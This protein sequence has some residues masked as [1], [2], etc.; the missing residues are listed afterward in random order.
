MRNKMM[1]YLPAFL[2]LANVLLFGELINMNPDPNGD[3]WIA[4][5]ISEPT[6]EQLARFNAMPVLK[7]PEFY[8]NR[9]D[10]LPSSIDNSLLPYFRPVFNQVNG[11]CG[12]ASGVGYN[13]TYEI[14]FERGTTADVPENQFPT[15][16]TYNFLNDG[17]DSGS[18]Y[19]DGWEI[20]KANGCPDVATYG[21]MS[22]EVNT[23][24]TWMSGYDKWQTGM[25]NRVKEQFNIPVSTPEGLQT[26]KHWFIDHADG[27][28]KGGVV[29]FAAGVSWSLG[30][31]PVGTPNAGQLV[32]KK[33]GTVMNHA[34]T[35]TGYNDSIRVDYNLDGRYTNDLDITGDGIIDMKDWEIGGL[36][37]VNSWGTGWGDSGKAWVMYRT[38][39]LD[40]S[41]GGIW[42]NVVSSLRAKSTVTPSLMMKAVI[43]HN[44]RTDL[45]I[46]AG[47]SSDT[48]ATVPEHTLS[49]P[50]F[51]YQGG[52][53][54]MEGDSNEVEFGLDITPLLS[55]V[56][57]DEP[58]KYFICVNEVDP[59]NY[60]EGEIIMFSVIDA[61]SNE[62][63]STQSN[64][65]IQDNSMT[66]MSLIKSSSF[67]PPQIITGS[68][69]AATQSEFYSHTLNSQSGS[70][71]YKWKIKYDYDQIENI[72]LF[73][74][75]ADS[76][77]ITS[78][79]DD[80]FGIIDLDFQFPF[81]GKLYDQVTVS[82][83]GS[84]LFGGAFEYISTEVN[85]IS[86]R[87]ISP[88]AADLSVNPDFEEGIIFYKNTEYL[89]VRWIASTYENPD[90][91]LDFAAK[92]YSNGNIEF[93]YG[94]AMSTDIIWAS[95][96]SDGSSDNCV[97]SSLS[98]INDPSG[99]K[100]KF[101]TADFP[102]GMQLSPEGTFSGTLACAPNS[103]DVTF[104]VIDYNNTS[105][106]KVLPFILAAPLVSPGN[107]TIDTSD[108]SA[109]LDWDPVSGATA[110]NIYRSN[111]PYGTYSKIGTSS[112]PNFEDTDLSGMNKYFYY[113]KADNS[114]K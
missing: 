91:D 114:K 90:A 80:G 68:L 69:P 33:W 109:F 20:I 87:N 43:S 103:W 25:N 74:E 24:T 35:F 16:H 34:M 9:K 19:F 96:I 45:K 59:Y 95:G 72:S 14:N 97:I 37:M 27:S 55:Y 62:T 3:P 56:D 71:P 30:T 4:G 1:R 42:N 49:F 58:V 104:M 12:Q 73:P 50:L 70:A 29:N 99:L 17:E 83:N 64:V 28:A 54:P 89:E 85:I 7:L 63:I 65:A 79:Y 26:L 111:L 67:N 46:F 38:L 66:Y 13:F 5:G 39:A 75:E 86:A 82:T 84:I 11:S 88:Y 76:L 102:Y 106:F 107:L 112:L 31:L 93:Y 81:Y 92:L 22:P 47:I 108:T 60:G 44:E 8:K 52:Y 105:S 110:Y 2:I 10:T 101:T 41:E 32:I 15:H 61:E 57:P 21:G 113:V 78:E 77:L 100:T 36:R 40:I 94:P 53:Y 48:T 51:V 6:L 98:N 18:W 23:L